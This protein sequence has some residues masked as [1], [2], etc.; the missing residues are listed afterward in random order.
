MALTAQQWLAIIPLP[1]VFML[2][3]FLEDGIR[4]WL[5]WFDVAMLLLWILLMSLRVPRGLF[6]LV[7]VGFIVG[8]VLGILQAFGHFRSRF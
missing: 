7:F 8:Y 4:T 2:S 3:P 1:P 6:A 5:G